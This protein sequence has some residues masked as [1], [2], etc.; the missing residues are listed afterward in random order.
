M[1]FPALCAL[2]LLLAVSS[3]LAQPPE[4]PERPSPAERLAQFLKRYPA[5]DANKDG[6]LTLEEMRAF[7]QTRQP[8]RV[9]SGDGPMPTHADVAYGEHPKQ[10][11]DIWLAESQD[12][13]PT[14][15]CIYIHGGGF[16][17][18]S[19]RVSAD[20]P[21]GYLRQ[22]VSF[23]SMEYRLSE[24][25]KHPYPIAMHDAARGLQFIRSQAK[26]WNLDPERVVCYGGSAGAG[27]SLWLAFHD[28]LADPTS[29]DPVARQS[30]R[31]LAAA[32]SNGQSTYDMRTFR[33]WFGVPDLAPHP[34]LTDFYAVKEP[35]DWESD[36]VKNLMTDAA[37]I[38]HL[39]Q[40][41]A[42]VFM[43]YRGGNVK[44]TKETNDG[45]WVHHPLLGLKLQ[46][47]MKELGLECVVDYPDHQDK[48]YGHMANFL[49]QK[50]KG[51]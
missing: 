1:K 46:E 4:R 32:T 13:K 16:R 9:R 31:I 29:D 7:Q 17:S 35:A 12:G 24:G 20:T 18:G 19:K 14:P 38:T 21:A 50:L 22:G 30:T 25:G 15:L 2:L 36:R 26:E 47:K 8:R 5:S 51:E 34:A 33:E 40:D 3:L 41:D 48:K 28:D 49:I 6:T 42:P 44:V 27:I 11:F 43:T 10:R 23:A 37:A 45:V 39:T